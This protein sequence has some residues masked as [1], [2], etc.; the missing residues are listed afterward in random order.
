M[1]SA[2][3]YA[4]AI[5]LASLALAACTPELPSPNLDTRDDFAQNVMTTAATGSV[6]Q[7]E[8]LVMDDRVNVRPE[9]DK[10][11]KF[12][13]GWSRD[14]GKI[15]ISND[16]PEVADVKVSKPGLATAGSFRITWN[17]D[18]WALLMGD[19]AT[20]PSGGASGGLNP[21]PEPTKS[22]G[23]SP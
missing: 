3:K 19:P 22:V 17:N 15:D 13:Q 5:L 1:H 6:E 10:L 2:R 4:A 23:T 11:V 20:P 14:S 7:V 21:T 8:K 12:A 18:H 9:V 16:F